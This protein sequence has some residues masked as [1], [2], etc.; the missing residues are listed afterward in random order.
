[1]KGKVSSHGTVGATLEKRLD[2][3]PGSLMLSGQLNHWTDESKFG[4]AVVL[5]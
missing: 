2:P 5:G 1:M 3:L 4:I